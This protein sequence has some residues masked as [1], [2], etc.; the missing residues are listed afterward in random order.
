MSATHSH[1]WTWIHFFWQHNSTSCS[2]SEQQCMMAGKTRNVSNKLTIC[3]FF[4]VKC[5]EICSRNLSGTCT[6][7]DSE[8]LP[9][10]AIGTLRLLRG[11][12]TI[13]STVLKHLDQNFKNLHVWSNCGVTS[14]HSLTTVSGWTGS[15]ADLWGEDNRFEAVRKSSFSS[16]C[17]LGPL[18]LAGWTRA[19]N[20]DQLY[21]Y[22]NH[23][24][25]TTNLSDI[26]WW[27][28]MVSGACLVVSGGV[29]WCLEH[30][31]W[32][33]CV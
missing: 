1:T 15:L 29:W 23:H 11:I 31:W 32:C 28:M 5:F 2:N 6:L 8:R 10:I 21:S 13:L 26:V 3:I 24:R 16:Q 25:T 17:F 33:Q 7:W 19:E 30:V 27:C 14:C 9:N 18:W 4:A 22:I 12:V 20:L